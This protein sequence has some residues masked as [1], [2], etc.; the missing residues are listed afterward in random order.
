MKSNEAA[1]SIFIAS[2]IIG[3]LISSNMNFS[4]ANT[5]VF[6]TPAE[7]EEAYNNTDKLNKGIDNLY[8]QYHEA[9]GKLL[10]YEDNINNKE[11]LLSEIN[12]E[13]YN[14]QLILG[15]VGVQGEGIIIHLEDTFD[16]FQGDVLDINEKFART[17]H[18]KDLV[19]VVN[20]LKVAGT[21]AISVNGHRITDGSS[22][23]CWGTL[24]EIDGVEIPGPFTIKA[25]GNKDK[26]YSYMSGEG[27]YLSFLNLRGLDVT[28]N[29]E[30]NIKI[31]ANEKSTY[32]E[33]MKESKIDNEK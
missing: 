31:L 23:L 6:L 15:N 32:I 10:T 1:V 13:I 22:I 19:S 27:G 29:K 8:K 14:N 12:K 28:M 4:N 26:L 11:K 24:I 33:Y 21:E 7:F 16:E 17:V 18:D 20:E 5:K 3:I 9:Y 30:N 25:I 2:T